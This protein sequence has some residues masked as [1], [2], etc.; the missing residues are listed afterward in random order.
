[1]TISAGAATTWVIARC[2]WCGKTQFSVLG[3]SGLSVRFTCND[4]GCK[5][6]QEQVL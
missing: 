5:M 3:G 4:R 1:M 2:K 6:T